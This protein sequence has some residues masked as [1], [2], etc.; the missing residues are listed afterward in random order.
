MH[1]ETCAHRPVD[2]NYIVYIAPK[3]TF[4]GPPLKFYSWRLRSNLAWATTPIMFLRLSTM[5]SNSATCFSKS[6]PRMT[7]L[8]SLKGGI[9]IMK[10]AK[11]SILTNGLSSQVVS[12]WSGLSRQGPSAVFSNILVSKQ[13]PSHFQQ[14]CCFIFHQNE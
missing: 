6:T 14:K 2:K 12:H 1:S 5:L 3:M 9:N 8:W 7:K 10:S 4:H 11:Q 13:K